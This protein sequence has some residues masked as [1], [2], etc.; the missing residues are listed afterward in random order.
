[1]PEHVFNTSW[2]CQGSQHDSS[3]RSS[4]QRF[5][6]KKGFL[7]N[8]AKFIGKHLCQSLVFNKVD[9]SATLLKKRLAQVFSYEFCEIFK[10]IFL[11]ENL[12]WLLLII[13]DIWQG[14]QYASGIKYARVLS[15]LGYSHNNIIIIVTNVIIEEFLTVWFAHPGASQ[16][17]ILSFLTIY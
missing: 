14:F 11:I 15:I 8:F 6:I 1:M 17:T 16:L 2:L 5:S 9:S 12:W 4:H 7:K 10:N 13:S 3:S